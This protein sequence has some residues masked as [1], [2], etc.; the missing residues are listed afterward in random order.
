MGH[1]ELAAPVTHIWYFKGVPSRLGSLR[2]LA[3]KELEKIIYFAAYVITHV[4]EA[5]RSRDLATL[6]TQ[7]RKEI[8]QIDVDAEAKRAKYAE[9]LEHRLAELESKGE[10]AASLNR[11]RKD[12][13]RQVK[14]LAAPRERD[15]APRA[16][17]WN[18]LPRQSPRQRRANERLC[19]GLRDPPR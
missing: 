13:A 5:K 3:P 18:T 11:A 10:K 9:D 19:A 15:P 8:A 14:G 7:V 17:P 6:E 2:D 12:T 16:Q 1:I 4:D